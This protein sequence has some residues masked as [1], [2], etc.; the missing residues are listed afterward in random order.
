MFLPLCCSDLEK[1]VSGTSFLEQHRK[2]GY[3]LE[4]R[5]HETNGR[6]FGHFNLDK[7]AKVKKAVLPMTV[8]LLTIALLV[9]LA[10]PVVLE[11]RFPQQVER[12]FST[13]KSGIARYGH[14]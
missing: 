9:T 5:K 11:G 4:K 1:L 7:Y 14:V 10:L 3:D 8:V 6:I 13:T 12:E 2:E